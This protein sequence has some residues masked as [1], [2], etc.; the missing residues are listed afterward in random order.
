[1]NI[2]MSGSRGAVFSKW[3]GAM[4]IASSA[5][6]AG[7]AS[8]PF[9]AGRDAGPDDAAI[10]AHVR[11]AIIRD[12]VLEIA[13]IDVRTKQ[14]IVQLSGFVPSADSV[15]AAASV[16]RSVKGVRSVRNDLR[17]K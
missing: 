6:L 4:T 16:A 12:P 5:A 11:E 7:C 3:L 10:T 2:D 14:G 1:M 8:N 17:L 13:D 9:D 15:G